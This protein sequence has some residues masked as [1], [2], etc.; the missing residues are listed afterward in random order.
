MLTRIG[1]TGTDTG[2]GKTVVAAALITMLRH[3][4]LRVAPM[5]PV[6]TG[7]GDDAARLLAAAGDLYPIDLVR[8]IA[9]AEPLA[10]LVAAQRA[11]TPIDVRVLDT[12][13]SQLRAMSDT[14]V[15]EGAGGLLVPVTETET[16]ATLFKRWEL[17]LIVV[18]A[19]RLGTV[20][21]TLLTVQ[22]AQAHGL[23]VRGVVLNTIS[24]GPSGV[25]E[26]TNR[27]L[28][29]EL[30]CTIPVVSVPHASTPYDAGP[31]TQS[32]GDLL[33]STIAPPA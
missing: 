3:N 20:N 17:E 25:A 15:V 4:T 33:S 23:T 13:F 24:N 22:C 10:P 11:G 21:H 26:Q 19:N 12:A 14:I 1:I 28:L 8:P 18:A 16:F 32:L 6:E 9:F 29:E 31:I 27:A 7:G 30:L 2:V 5:K